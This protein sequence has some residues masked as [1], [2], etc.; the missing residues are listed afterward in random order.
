MAGRFGPHW[1]SNVSIIP[2]SSV[3]R[4]RLDWFNSPEARSRNVNIS[5][6]QEQGLQE[7]ARQPGSAVGRRSDD[8]VGRRARASGNT[9]VHKPRA[10]RARRCPGG[11]FPVPPPE[12]QIG[13]GGLPWPCVQPGGV[14]ACP[15]LTE[16]AL[17]SPLCLLC[18]S[19]WMSEDTLF[20]GGRPGAPTCPFLLGGSVRGTLQPSGRFPRPCAPNI[21]TEQRPVRRRLSENAKQPVFLTRGSLFGKIGLA[22]I[23]SVLSEFT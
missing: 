20:P 4:C 12:D 22:F 11:A 7:K 13:A 19:R 16:A 15:P 23:N 10:R 18:P 17:D 3:E 9:S 21:A 6:R 2:E 14:Q 5:S 1:C 8:S